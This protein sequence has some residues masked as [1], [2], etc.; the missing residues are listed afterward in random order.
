MNVYKIVAVTFALLT[1]MAL[2]ALAAWGYT[3]RDVVLEKLSGT[4]CCTEESAACCPQ[5][6]TDAECC[7][8]AG[9]AGEQQETQN[10]V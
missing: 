6:A 2:F 1:A 3:K 5:Q 7:P 10:G 9:A 8:A 4:P